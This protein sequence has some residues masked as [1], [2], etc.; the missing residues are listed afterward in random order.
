MEEGCLAYKRCT[1]GEIHAARGVLAAAYIAPKTSASGFLLCA[2][3][4]LSLNNQLGLRHLRW[5]SL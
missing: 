1:A 4:L 5:P 2:K 3:V